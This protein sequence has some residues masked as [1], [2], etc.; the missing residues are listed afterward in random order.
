MYFCDECS[1]GFVNK[2]NL[3]QHYNNAHNQKKM[4]EKTVGVLMPNKGI[5]CHEIIF[6]EFM[7]I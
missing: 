4:D 5:F 7:N 2:S 1:K 3:K 6:K